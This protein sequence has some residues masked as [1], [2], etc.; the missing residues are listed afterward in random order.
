MNKTIVLK[1]GQSIKFLDYTIK[2][3]LN[4]DGLVLM[5]PE[6][7]LYECHLGNYGEGTQ[8]NVDTCKRY[9]I[10]YYMCERP[11]R[12]ATTLVHKTMRLNSGTQHE[13]YKLRDSLKKDNIPMPEEI[14][15]GDHLNCMIWFKGKPLANPAKDE[16]IIDESF[17]ANIEQA[18]N[19]GGGI[20]NDVIR[21]KNGMVIRISDDIIAIYDNEQN[22][23]S[24]VCHTNAS[25]IPL[26]I[27]L[28]FKN[29]KTKG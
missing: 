18:T 5:K 19:T 12:F 11:D 15:C 6:G 16:D 22:D 1:K 9:A 4:N 13:W 10:M 29:H 8:K 27:P 21:L 23:E 2:N 26:P 7:K 3:S 24:G 14:T 28:W 20:H 17:I 25:M